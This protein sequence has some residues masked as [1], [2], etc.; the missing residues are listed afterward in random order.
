MKRCGWRSCSSILLLLVYVAGNAQSFS[1]IKENFVT[2]DKLRLTGDHD[3]IL[4][5]KENA[6]RLK[7]VIPEAQLIEIKDAGHEIPRTHPESIVRAPFAQL[8]LSIV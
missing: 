8:Q 6:Y 2:V 1:A 3:A 5:A 4:S 7:S